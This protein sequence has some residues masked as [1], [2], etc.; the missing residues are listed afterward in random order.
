[1]KTDAIMDL[2]A[3]YKAYTEAEELDIATATPPASTPVCMAVA[4]AGAGWII[5]QFTS[6]VTYNKNC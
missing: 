4:T 5:S 3:G 1:M 2:V 6:K